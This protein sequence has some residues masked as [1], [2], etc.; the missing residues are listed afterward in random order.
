MKKCIALA[1][2][3]LVPLLAY[4]CGGGSPSDVAKAFYK[5]GNEGNYSKAEGYLSFEARVVY[6]Q[7][8]F[9]VTQS[10]DNQMDAVTKAGT[11]TRIDVE[12]GKDYGGYAVVLVTLHYANGGQASDTLALLK[13]DGQWRIVTSTLLLTAR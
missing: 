11:I 12:E 4:G 3:A 7:P 13:E 2:F 8:M 6:K 10:F 5:A 1:L 9:G